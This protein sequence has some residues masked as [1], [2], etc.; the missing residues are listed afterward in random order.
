MTINEQREEWVCAD[1]LDSKY[2]VSYSDGGSTVNNECVVYDRERSA[3][4]KWVDI[5]IEHFQVFHDAD[6]VEKKIFVDNS[7]YRVAELDENY[8]TDRGTAITWGFKTRMEDSD[9]P[10]LY[11]HLGWTDLRFRDVSGT[12]GINLYVDNEK[13]SYSLQIPPAYT[14][15]TLKGTRFRSTRLRVSTNQSLDIAENVARKRF[16][17]HRLGQNS[18][19]RSFGF[20]VEGSETTSKATLLDIEFEMKERSERYIPLEE[21]NQI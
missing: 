16:P 6:E 21:V 11:K 4:T 10:N 20:E 13:V 15:T 18:V 17:F 5:G 1:Y 2:I 14:S 8:T 9:N 12:L 7:D 3:F 19:G